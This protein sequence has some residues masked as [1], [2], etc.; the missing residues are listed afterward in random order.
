MGEGTFVVYARKSPGESKGTSIRYQYEW[1]IGEGKR[2]GMTLAR[3]LGSA[4]LHGRLAP[5]IEGAYVDEGARGSRLKVRAGLWKMLLDGMAGKFNAVVV[6]RGD[7]L[8][9]SKVSMAYIVQ[10]LSQYGVRL[11]AGDNPTGSDLVG[12]VA[13]VLGEY[14]RKAIGERTTQ[15]LAQRAKEIR[16]GRP[17]KGFIADGL[18]WIPTRAADAL[19]AQYRSGADHAALLA[20]PHAAAPT[21]ENPGTLN[22]RSG[23]SLDGFLANM[24]AYEA[25]HLEEHL[26]KGRPGRTVRKDRADKAD[27]DEERALQHQLI[28]FVPDIR[29]V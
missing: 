2:L 27:A 1:G 23:T 26:A 13:A 29:K 20:S 19:Y 11:I 25:G 17:P 12:G 15:S 9:R 18:R 22:I 5:V 4:Y 8:S 3:G 21:E 10:A 14:E 28:D 16:L 24:R 7:R 6:Y